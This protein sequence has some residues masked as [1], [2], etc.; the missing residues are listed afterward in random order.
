MGKTTQFFIITNIRM[1]KYKKED[2]RKNRNG[3]RGV[4]GVLG[5][6]ISLV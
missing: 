2:T 6:R 5:R 3:K 4:L 1:N